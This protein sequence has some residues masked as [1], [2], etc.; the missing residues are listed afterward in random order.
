V[1]GGAV[2]TVEG[3]RLLQLLP[4]AAKSKLFQILLL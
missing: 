4:L 3:V 2:N 1:A